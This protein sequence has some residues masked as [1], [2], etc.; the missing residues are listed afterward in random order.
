MADTSG[1]T[2][3]Y[4]VKLSAV[5]HLAFDFNES[6]PVVPMPGKGVLEAIIAEHVK[7]Q[8]EDSGAELIDEY[9]LLEVTAED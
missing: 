7:R 5:V 3:V 6:C 4:E 1:L 9:T 8:L 2:F